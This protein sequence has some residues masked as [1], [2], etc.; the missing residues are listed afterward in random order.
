[1]IEQTKGRSTIAVIL[2]LA[3][4]FMGAHR[5]DAGEDWVTYDGADG[6]GK[7]KHIVLVSGDEEYRS[8]EC[9]PMLGKILAKH[10][11]FTCTVLFSVNDKGE[12]DPTN[13]KSVT[14]AKAFD[15]ADLIVMALR[16]RNWPDKDMKHFVDAYHRGVPIVGLRTS[17]HGFKMG[18]NSA[19]RDFSRFGKN[20][21]GEGW[22]SHWGHHK[23]E[24]CRGVV[25]EANKNH[26]IL[27]DATDVF[28]DSDTYEA[29]P[30]ED[31]TILM[32]GVVTDSLKPDSK[33][34]TGKKKKN[35]KSGKQQG[36]NDPAMPVAW[37]REYKNPKGKTNR[38]FCTTMGAAS[39]FRSE[40]LRRMVVNSVYWGLGLDVPKNAKVTPIGEWDPTFYG[41]GTYKKGVKPSDHK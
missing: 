30:P 29:Y 16:F 20:V 11:G 26:P 38:I 19:Y 39:D 36:V 34:V 25:E 14:N 1:M 37:T 4:A 22:V 2:G 12:I 27:T 32:R 7:G 17:T 6:P 23:R 21:L 10:H 5:L 35:R 28:A 9:L 3:A 15:S 8:E 31:A 24:G 40:G 41:F 33:P 18:G 13:Q